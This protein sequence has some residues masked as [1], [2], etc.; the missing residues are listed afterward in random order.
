MSLESF[1][2]K[3]G[4]WVTKNP[5]RIITILLVITLFMFIQMQN[6]H[7]VA[8]DNSDALPKDNPVMK[9]FDIIGEKFGSSDSAM[10]VFEL[11][12]QTKDESIKDLREPE[13][14]K[15]MYVLG[16]LSKGVSNVED[17][18]SIAQDIKEA[19]NGVL[20]KTRN[21][22]IEIMTEN[23]S[24]AAQMD[25]YYQLTYIT[26]RLNPDYN[27]D[28]LFKELN[29]AVSQIPPIDGVKVSAGGSALEGPAVSQ[30][31]SS[32]MGKTS[33]FS[34]L[35]ILII[36]ILVFRSIKFGLTPLTTIIVGIVWTMGFAGI[37]GMNLSSATS[38][39]LSMIMGIGIDFGI[40][41]VSRFRQE[42]ENNSIHDSIG[43]TLNAVFIPMTT[44]TFAAVIGFQ[45]MT[46]GQITFLAEMGQIMSFG[47]VGCYLAALAFI[48][49]ILVLTNK[50]KKKVKK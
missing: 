49:P 10:I 39:V 24:I 11:D 1:F 48:P 42:I 7:T 13:V 47:V 26:I 34:L 19:N 45:A 15:Q 46:L 4:H 38:G 14:I 20:P 17:V 25:Q 8:T 36:V 41:I 12:P 16:E 9:S 44:T 2:N 3:Y 43:T 28:E 37:L 6:V 21:E 22:I 50:D 31:I 27:E 18:S 32:D 29:N 33:M 5:I 40:Q 35:A 30:T 23:P